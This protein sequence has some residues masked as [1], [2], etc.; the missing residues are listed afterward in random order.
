MIF[1]LLFGVSGVCA[2]DTNN[3]DTATDITDLNFAIVYLIKIMPV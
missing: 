1:V 3:L 2:Q